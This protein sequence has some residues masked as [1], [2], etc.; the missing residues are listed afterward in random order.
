MKG[1]QDA[2][3]HSEFPCQ[4]R[5]V[6]PRLDKVTR[7]LVLAVTAV[8]VV[9]TGVVAALL[10]SANKDVDEALEVAKAL[11]SVAGS[12][13]VTGVLG[14]FITTT[15]A[16]RDHARAER[17]ESARLASGALRDLKAA[18]EKAQIAR[19]MLRFNPTTGMLFEQAPGLLEARAL[20]Q[21]V[22]RERGLL[23]TPADEGAQKMLDIIGAVLQ[24][25]AAH[26]YQLEADRE[27]EKAQASGS[28]EQA[29]DRRAMLTDGS[30]FPHV[31][32]FIADN[33]S[34]PFVLA[35]DR[36]KKW[37]ADRVIEV[38]SENG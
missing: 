25:Y 2:R 28:R 9:L 14:V 7:D 8:L 23:G 19:F 1:L 27:A 34:A 22:Q 17:E 4:A 33:K 37:L 10:A 21:R 5:G 32:E 13:A 30:D 6:G 26:Y 18:F 35:Y 11:I 16:R 31:L 29:T 3:P 20:L 38:N 15:L 24:E 36:A 12:V